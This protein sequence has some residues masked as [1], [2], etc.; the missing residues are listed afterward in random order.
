[1]Y[2]AGWFTILT[3]IR[4]LTVAHTRQIG[5]CIANRHML[6]RT[7][8]AMCWTGERTPIAE[9][10]ATIS[11][12]FAQSEQE[13]PASVLRNTVPDGIQQLWEH[14]VSSSQHAPREMFDNTQGRR[15]APL[16]RPKNAL[17]VLQQEHRRT[18]RFHIPQE[19]IDE[20]VVWVLAVPRIA[21]GVRE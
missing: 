18:E 2:L 19:D 3:L 6:V 1:K 10:L 4:G 17:D 15:P 8:G 5:D 21:I 9:V 11:E 16:R 12:I 20:P 13:E 14:L 7:S